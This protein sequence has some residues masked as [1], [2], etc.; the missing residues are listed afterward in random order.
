MRSLYF[1]AFY[2]F[3]LNSFSQIPR[4]SDLVGSYTFSGNANDSSGNNHHA[5]TFGYPALTE[6]RHGNANSA[7]YFDGND[8][9]YAGNAMA[10]QIGNK[11]TI[12]AWVQ[13]T[14]NQRVD[15]LGLGR[16]VCSNQAGPR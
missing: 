13:S 8:Y 15:M 4:T 7:Y 5:A 12:S 9:F 14:N 10:N 3:C 11:F 6:D 2:L 16:A 1:I